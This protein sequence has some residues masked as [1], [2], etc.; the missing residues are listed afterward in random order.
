[1][2]LIKMHCRIH[3]FL[4]IIPVRIDRHRSTRFL[5]KRIAGFPALVRSAAVLACLVTAAAACSAGERWTSLSGNNTVEAE[6]IG[7]WGSNVVLELPGPR[8]V[9]VNLDDLIA[10]SRIQARQM[11]EDQRLRRSEMKQQILAEAKEAAAPAPTPIPQPPAPPAYQPFTGTGALAQLEWMD[12]QERNGHSLLAQF[13]SLPPGYQSDVERLLRMVVAKL[14]MQGT[15]QVIGSLHSVG[16]LI[17]TRQRWL[18]SHP[19]FAAIDET[20]KNSLE[21]LLL[22]VGG[23]IRNGFDP[24]QLKLEEIATTPLR[25]WL[26]EFDKRT[27]PYEVAL[28]DQFQSLGI[29]TGSYEVLEEKEGSAVVQYSRGTTKTPISMVNV[30][31][32]WLPA[33]IGTEKWA[34]T[35]KNWEESLAA[36]A[37]GTLLAGA[38]A[39]FASVVIAAS[40]QPALG[41]KNAR[42]FHTVMDGWFAQISPLIAQMDM[43][44]LG[45]RRQ[46]G[47]GGDEYGD[48]TDY[49]DDANM[50]AGDGSYE[51][52]MGMSSSGPGPGT[53]SGP[54]AS[55]YGGPSMSS[56]PPGM[57]SG[58]PGMSG[59]S[60]SSGP[61]SGSGR[62]GGFSGPPGGSSGPPGGSSRPGGF[63][64][65]PGGSSGPPSGSSRPTGSSGPP[66]GSGRPG[67]SSRPSGS[68]R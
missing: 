54:P 1:M 31:G 29:D 48:M 10:E 28:R 44:N 38:E 65:P 64:G 2:R 19:R 58:R 6:F 61:P 20:A 42:E 26:V 45:G 55:L 18:F 37:D 24:D 35:T 36:T 15:R 23:L 57:S 59:P 25:Q 53:S 22:S 49:Y 7:L 68:G 34:E 13:D 21:S 39:Q 41:A 66:S 43:L 30:E 56:A 67:G 60:M 27:A 14:D 51:Q 5:G 40:I 63:S 62:P 47:Y 32:K 3:S 9:S 12:Q 17:V 16:D 4:R 11:A 46:N 50:N 52:Q 33:E 8:R